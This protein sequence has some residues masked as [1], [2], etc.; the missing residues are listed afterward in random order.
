M[1]SAPLHL[2]V[3]SALWAQGRVSGNSVGDSDASALTSA[4]QIVHTANGLS[5]SGGAL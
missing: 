5:V 1:R 4:K 2:I 3:I